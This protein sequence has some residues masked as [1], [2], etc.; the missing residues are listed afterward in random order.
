LRYRYLQEGTIFPD[1]VEMYDPW[2][3]RELLHNC[4]AHQDYTMQSRIN[5][6]EYEDGKLI[7]DNS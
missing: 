7:F 4:I 2:V 3:L 1:E 5:I 6:V